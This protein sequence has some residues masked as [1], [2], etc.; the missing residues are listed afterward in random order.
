MNFKSQGR[1]IWLES[2]QMGLCV[3]KK[4]RP[5]SDDAW[6]ERPSRNLSLSASGNQHNQAPSTKSEPLT[7]PDNSRSALLVCKSVFAS[8]LHP[9]RNEKSFQP[10]NKSIAFRLRIKRDHSLIQKQQSVREY[11]YLLRISMLLF[12]SLHFSSDAIPSLNSVL[13]WLN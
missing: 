8:F 7:N 10:I 1:A 6:Q 9:S 4:K 5:K 3:S 11:P 2:Y 13:F 12:A